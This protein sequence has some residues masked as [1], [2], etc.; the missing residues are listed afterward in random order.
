MEKLF[1]LLYMTTKKLSNSPFAPELPA[2]YNSEIEYQH[3][4]KKDC[5]QK[6]YNRHAAKQLDIAQSGQNAKR[7]YSQYDQCS[8]KRPRGTKKYG[9]PQIYKKQHGKKGHTSS[10]FDSLRAGI[11]SSIEHYASP[12][13]AE[14][15]IPKH[16]QK[17]H[18][19]DRRHEAIKRKHHAT[20]VWTAAH[21]TNNHTDQHQHPR[22]DQQCNGRAIR[23]R[24]SHPSTPCSPC[25]LPIQ[26]IA[27]F[28]TKV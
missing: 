25:F 18:C 6:Q 12:C 21:P 16:P 5:M 15:C 24:A 20:L 4:D 8:K 23:Q 19:P 17:R 7:Q 2:K 10:I 3:P 27:P 11:T 1:I 14:Q 13:R 9:I 26:K 22:A 28:H